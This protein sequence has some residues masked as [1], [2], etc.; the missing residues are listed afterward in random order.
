MSTDTK[1]GAKVAVIK[2]YLKLKRSNSLNK[3]AIT[4]IKKNLKKSID[5]TNLIK[6]EYSYS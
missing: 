2:K 6:S 4:I 1:S 3:Y 5:F